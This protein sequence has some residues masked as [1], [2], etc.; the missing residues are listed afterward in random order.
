MW[1]CHWGSTVGLSVTDISDVSRLAELAETPGGV[2]RDEIYLAVASLFRSQDNNLSS[3]ERELMRDIL[4]RLTQQV[5]MTIRIA[6]AERLADDSNAPHEL[7]LMLADDR[8]EVARPVLLRSPVLSD[9]DLIRLI[10]VTAEEHHLAVASRPH[11]GEGVSAALTHSGTAPVIVTL[12]R[13]ETAR[14]AR[15]TV[16][17]IVELSRTLPDLQEPLVHRRDLPRMLAGRMCEWVSDSLKAFISE[18]FEVDPGRVAEA[19]DDAAATVQ[20]APPQPGSN[21]E[22]LIEKLAVAGQLKAGFL[23]RVL[24]QGQM[25]LFELGFAR[26]LQA[27]PDRV[28]EMLYERGPKA[29]AL[30]CRAVGIDRAVFPT[31]FT[32]IHQNRGIHAILSVDDR[33]TV[34][35]VF[36]VTSRP[37]AL[38]HLQSV[39]AA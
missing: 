27:E 29:L 22:K 33:V 4:R 13:N 31:V 14:L 24:H 3:R 37:A 34:D 23:I 15:E 9:A 18:K 8:I 10:A 12:L 25:E 20:A 19:L 5:E 32:L 7:V 39:L 6:L 38:Q 16:E 17:E 2:R 36:A 11:I 1:P 21:A 35:Q 28:R 26:L 30:A